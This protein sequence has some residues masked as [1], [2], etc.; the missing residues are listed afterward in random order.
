[1]A[2]FDAKNLVISID[3]ATINHGEFGEADIEINTG[4]ANIEIK[5]GIAGGS[6][7]NAKY[8]KIDELKFSLIAESS[9]AKR[10]RKYHMNRKTVAILV[11][12]LS[13][14]TK[15]STDI[16]YVETYDAVTLN[17]DNLLAFTLK[18]EQDFVIEE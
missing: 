8:D 16:A 12:D 14:N 4:G 11:K 18:C 17:K 13:T 2:K 7:T 1:M 15:Y 5:K 3:G 9:S 6:W 10:L